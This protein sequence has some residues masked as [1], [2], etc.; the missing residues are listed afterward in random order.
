MAMIAITVPEDVTDSLERELVNGKKCGPETYHITMFYIEEE[1]G[2]KDVV[3]ILEIMHSVL[4]NTDGF[5]VKGAKI[6]TFP[7]GPDG[8]PVIVPI[9]SKDLFDLREAMAKKF[10]A[11]KIKYS[12]RFPK[13]QPHLTLSYASKEQEEKKLEKAVTWKVPNIVLFAGDNME[14]GVIV[15]VPLRKSKRSRHELL[16]L[17]CEAY[18]QYSY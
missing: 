16:G 11:N 9:E 15:K 17:F 7:K 13:Y 10:D 14:D 12:K 8:V 6:S 2:I 5:K 3:E 18:L 4:K 1:L